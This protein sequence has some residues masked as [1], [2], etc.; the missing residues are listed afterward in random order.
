M[1]TTIEPDNFDKT[2][3]RAARAV[4]QLR[5]PSAPP[6]T[7]QARV[8]NLNSVRATS[9]PRRVLAVAAIVILAAGLT[10]M[11]VHSNGGDVA[12]GQVLDN[13]RKVRTVTYKELYKRE[14]WEPSVSRETVDMSGKYSRTEMLDEKGNVV[15]VAIYNGGRM[16]N[17][18]PKQK[19][20][21]LTDYTTDDGLPHT[22]ADQATLADLLKLQAPKATPLGKRAIDGKELAGFRVNR[23]Y[24]RFYKRCV[25]VWVDP[26]TG[27]PARV[28]E[29]SSRREP[30]DAAMKK[31]EDLRK[32]RGVDKLPPEEIQKLEETWPEVKESRTLTDIRFDVP[33]DEK[34]FNIDPPAGYE[35]TSK[36]VN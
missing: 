26:K 27:L 5:I 13:L 29:T 33:I 28:V 16:L 9:W 7:V 36:K 23:D 11:L 12:F 22:L 30:D 18:D 35:F 24:D 14:G 4:R 3:D 19:K 20:A 17:I 34:T 2:I 15:G 31:I 6:A 21:S 10:F 8:R 1:T 25:D 32:A